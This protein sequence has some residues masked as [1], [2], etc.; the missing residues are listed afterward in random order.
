LGLTL[1]YYLFK[2]NKA[3]S[4][5][6]VCQ[7]GIQLIEALSRIHQIGYVHNDLKLE[8]ILVGDKNEEEMHFIKL[9][10]FGL[11]SRYLDENG[12]H[13]KEEY[14]H[15]SGNIA[16]GSKNAL[17]N[18]SPS[19]RDDL[20]SLVYLLFYLHTGSLNFLHIDQRT[21]TDEQYAQAKAVSTASSICQE[22]KSVK[23]LEFAQEIY[24]LKFE[25]K[26][27]YCKLQV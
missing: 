22:R 1:K 6:T 2:R 10:D 9:I 19:R 11:S 5:Q 24:S 8:N 3:F 14:R 25:E 18:I 13:I 12:K 21:A 15:F 27:D 16:F 7:I 26:P 17:L 4:L 23:F 20:F